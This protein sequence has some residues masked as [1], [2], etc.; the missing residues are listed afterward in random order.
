VRTATPTIVTAASFRLHT[1]HG[2]RLRVLVPAGQTASGYVSGV[3]N[4]ARS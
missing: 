2:L 3:S 1:R 4:I